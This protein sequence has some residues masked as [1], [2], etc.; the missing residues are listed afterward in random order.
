MPF[1]SGCGGAVDLLLEPSHTPEFC[2]LIVALERSSR[3]HGAQII[4]WLPTAQMPKHRA[5]LSESGQ[6]VFRSETLTPGEMTRALKEPL[7]EALVDLL[8]PPLR[9]VV[10]GAGEDARPVVSIAGLLGWRIVVVDG[11]A[12]LAQRTRFPEAQEVLCMHAGRLEELGTADSDAFVLMTHSYEQDLAWLSALLIRK[13]RYVGLLGAKHRS[14][15]LLHTVSEQIGRPL[16]ECCKEVS[17]PI[18]LNLGA[19]G[20]QEIALAIVAE[21]QAR[22]QNDTRPAAPTLAHFR[23]AGSAR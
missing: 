12:H 18:S 19:E 23:R 4:T 2:A 8:R 14:R 1:G 21:I 17:F 16:D 11:R 22:L 5:V 3:G 13:P 9:L 15:Q 6:I 20:P 10:I 7:Q